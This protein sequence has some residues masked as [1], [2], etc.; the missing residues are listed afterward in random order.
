MK[1]YYEKYSYKIIGKN[2]HISFLFKTDDVKFT[3][4]V[5]IENVSLKGKDK[6]VIDNLVF[7]L[8]MIE[9]FSYWKATCYP[10]IIIRAGALNKKQVAWWE[11]LL[12]NGMDNSFMRIKLKKH[13]SDLF[14]KEK[15]ILRKEKLLAKK[16]LIPVG[17]GKDSAVTL[18]IFKESNPACFSLN[19]DKVILK[20]V[21]KRELIIARRK[22]EKNLL[23]MNRKG[24]YN[25]HTPFVAYL[26]FLS[27]L[28]SYLF[29]KKY[30][31][32]SNEDSA[33]EEN[34][35]WQGRKINHQYSKTYEFEK[36]FRDYCSKYLMDNVEYFSALR[37]LYELQIGLIFSHM[38]DYHHIFLSCNEANKTILEQKRKQGCGVIIVQNAF[39]LLN[40]LSVFD[41]KELL[42]I[43]KE[44]LFEN[45]KLLPI[46]KELTGEKKVNHLNVL[47]LGVRS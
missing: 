35:I 20:M 41:K 23:D 45:K 47:A 44:D 33:N 2:L 43:F 3:P 40:T 27:I 25:G 22:I 7:N 26:S 6:K 46:L 8:G 4:N 18:N 5:I 12:L 17:G 38:K 9:M 21:G 13:L 19:P 28:V 14:L 37:M 1:F 24:F 36:D 29:N 32:F 15:V 30:I 10:Q 39:Y 31:A 16:I 42:S 34:V 11:K